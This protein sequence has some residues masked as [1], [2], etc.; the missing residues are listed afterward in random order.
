[1]NE[2]ILNEYHIY[3]VKDPEKSPILPGHVCYLS[4]VLLDFKMTITDRFSF[5]EGFDWDLSESTWE[6]HFRK[7]QSQDTE[8][9][10]VKK[11]MKKYWDAQYGAE[12]CL[13]RDEMENQWQRHYL[14]FFLGALAEEVEVSNEDSRR[15]V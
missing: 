8:K 5:D 2:A 14:D 6:E 3:Y 12:W 1:M 7:K 15:Y 9:Y 4:G 10:A 13:H 11:A